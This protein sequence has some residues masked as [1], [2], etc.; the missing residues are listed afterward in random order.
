MKRILLVLMALALSLSLSTGVLGASP[1]TP[2]KSLCFSDGTFDYA[3]AIKLT[4]T[5]KSKSGTPV[6]FYT[7]SGNALLPGVV[8]IAV[9]GAGRMENAPF[10]FSLTGT[11]FDGSHRY[12]L[13]CNG[14]W[15]LATS[16]G[17]YDR[18]L[19]YDA[20]PSFVH[21]SLTALDC[22]NLDY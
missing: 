2:P 21:G 17:L 6:K 5:V 14:Q 18:N 7:I 19:E 9:T 12:A 4:G 3:L 15:N 8:K 11:G 16:A 1:T 20:V 10:Y 13:F 22:A